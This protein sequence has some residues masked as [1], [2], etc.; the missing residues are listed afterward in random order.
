[1]G[2]DRVDLF[3]LHCANTARTSTG[4]LPECYLAFGATAYPSMGTLVHAQEQCSAL[5]LRALHE[6]ARMQLEEAICLEA[7]DVEEIHIR[8]RALANLNAALAALIAA[9]RI[10]ESEFEELVAPAR[11]MLGDIE[12]LDRAPLLAEAPPTQGAA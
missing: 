7:D 1:M 6:N 5:G 8:E 12:L 10:S 11:G 4:G 9:P 3:V 2:T